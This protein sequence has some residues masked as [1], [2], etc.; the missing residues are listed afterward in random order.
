VDARDFIRAH[1]PVAPAPAVP[2]VRLHLATPAS[3]ISRLVG[4]RVEPPY[5]AY[6]WAGGAVLARFVLDRPQTVRRRRV[7]DLGSG[8]G[9]VA[10]AALKAGADA[11]TAAEIDPN[12]RAALAL[13]AKLNGV[14]VTAIAD[15][16]L[17]GGPP[18]ADLVLV[19]DLFYATELAERVTAF[20]DRCRAEGIEVLV[21]DIGRS[22][23]P[24]HR[25]RL[26]D[27]NAVP[28]F[29]DGADSPLRRSGVYAWI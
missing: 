4:A 16:L 19:G 2:E 23:L 5:W 22:A 11:A 17:A 3:R 28:D 24:R 6:V 8:S 14:E 25:L 26:I 29:G 13:N 12:G 27:E 10:I 1:L 7:L 21:G 18:D 20:L 9:L 15:D